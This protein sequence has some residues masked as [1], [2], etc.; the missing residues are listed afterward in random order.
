MEKGLEKIL[1]LRLGYG[2][3]IG[4]EMEKSDETSPEK[5]FATILVPAPRDE[6]SADN[7]RGLRGIFRICN[8]RLQ[9]GFD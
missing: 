5:L 3:R 7:L 2:I 8:Q 1:V 9:G 4:Q 6:S